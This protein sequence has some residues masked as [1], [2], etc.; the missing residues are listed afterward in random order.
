MKNPIIEIPRANE[1]LI[2]ALINAG[3]LIVTEN[4]LTTKE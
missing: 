2:N 3:I 1:N 4:G